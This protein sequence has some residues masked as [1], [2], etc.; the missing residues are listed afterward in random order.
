MAIHIHEEIADQRFVP[1]LVARLQDTLAPPIV[2]IPTKMDLEPFRP[3]FGL[4]DARP[5]LDALIGG[6]DW[7]RDGTVVRFVVIADDIQLKPARFNFAA[8]A[9][10]TSTPFHLSIVSLARLQQLTDGGRVDRDPDRTAQRVFKLIAKN[11]ARLMGYASSDACLFA[12]PRSISELDAT[13]ENF[14]EPDL[15]ALVAAGIARSP[16]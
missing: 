3:M 6:I 9:G 14:C 13:P 8:S 5:L 7:R 11:T 10:D 12:F 1:K 16:Q 15:S 4:M 2:T